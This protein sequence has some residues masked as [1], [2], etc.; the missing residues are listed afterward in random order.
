MS[1]RLAALSSLAL[2]SLA[3]PACVS[4]TDP[5]PMAEAGTETGDTSGAETSETGE[6]GETGDGDGDV[7]P[8]E[9]A[10]ALVQYDGDIHFGDS[11]TNIANLTEW[12]LEA[13]ELGAKII[14]QPEGSTYGYASDTEVWCAPGETEYFDLDCRDVSTVAEPLPGGS[15]TDHWAELAAEH[16][17]YIVYHVPEVDGATY[18]TSLGVVGPEG[19]V[20]RYRKRDLYYIDEAFAEPGDE[21]VILETPYGDFGLMICLDGTYN[22][23]NYDEYIAQGIDDIIIAMDWDD[24]PMGPFA[25]ESWFADR[26]A[27]NN[28][29]IYASDVSKWDGTAKYVP[30]GPRERVGLPDQAIGIDGLSVH[31]FESAP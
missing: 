24:D 28:V 17:V 23:D 16:E 1:R 5:D 22:G 14:V 21:G 20:T 13:I 26:A 7:E 12:T 25:A 31:L 29:T 11:A 18:H 4:E 6:T 9:P 30:D 3:A 10:I 27:D 8:L 15:T 19:F 2:V